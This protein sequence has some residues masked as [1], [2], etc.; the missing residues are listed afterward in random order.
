MIWF[1]KLWNLKHS[2]FPSCIKTDSNWDISKWGN[3]FGIMS[4]ESITHRIL[5][6]LLLVS[7]WFV[8]SYFLFLP[9]CLPMLF[10]NLN[11]IFKISKWIE[12]YIWMT[13]VFNTVI[14]LLCIFSFCTDLVSSA[15][16]RCG[17]EETQS[18]T[19]DSLFL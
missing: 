19:G 14:S 15:I 12:L 6:L 16:E 1:L 10:T 7:S 13:N 3:K 17:M 8:S 11:R 5:Q 18:K 9:I 2:H 4:L